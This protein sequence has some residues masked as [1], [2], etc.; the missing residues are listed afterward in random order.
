MFTFK[1]TYVFKQNGVEIGRSE[2]II[3]SNGRKM[4]LQYL[5]GLRQDW[6]AD[7]AIGAISSQTSINDKQLSFETGRYP[8]TLKTL[9]AASSGNPDLIVV[10]GTIPE[11][12]YANIYEIGLYPT[13]ALS[14]AASRNN[15]ILE[16]FS[17]VNNWQVIDGFVDVQDFVASELNSPRIGDHSAV[18]SP[19]S[20][21]TNSS[22][23]VPFANY[24]SLD[25]LELLL[26]DS[27]AGTLTLVLTDISGQTE[28]LNYSIPT[29]SNAYA[30]ALNFSSN[31]F[32]FTNIQSI[33][34]STDSTAATTLDAI[35]VSTSE[36]LSVEETLVSRSSLSTP[37]GKLYNVPIDI[38]YY[39]ELL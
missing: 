16:D 38:E 33:S 9:I 31:I 10:R 18:I 29:S 14:S 3:T 12:I 1:G 34:I 4:I 19:N 22:L 15:K 23:S 17:Y 2:N 21:Y 24:T 39:I 35:K 8:V 7:F 13:S 28:T 32:N 25:K 5:C 26:K 36:E 27:V 20:V 30:L 37:I 11:N 6:A